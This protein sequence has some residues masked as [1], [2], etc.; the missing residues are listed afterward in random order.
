V[1]PAADIS[2]AGEQDVA[3]GGRGQECADGNGFF[4]SGG[5]GFPC[6]VG[7]RRPHIGGLI[8]EEEIGEPDAVRVERV[9][10]ETRRGL[11]D[12]GVE[13]RRLGL[14]GDAVH[15]G[16]GRSAVV[17]AVVIKRSVARGEHAA[18]H[19]DLKA[20]LRIDRDTRI[21]RGS[22]RSDGGPDAA[23]PLEYA[24]AV[25]SGP[26]VAGRHI[27]R[28]VGMRGSFDYTG[29]AACHQGERGAAIG[30]AMH[31][32]GAADVDVFGDPAEQ[33]AADV[34]LHEA[35]VEVVDLCPRSTGVGGL[36]RAVRRGDRRVG[37][38]RDIH[39][40]AVQRIDRDALAGALFVVGFDVDQDGAGRP[41]VTPVG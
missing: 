14:V 35:A 36:E 2:H 40:I 6:D 3:A 24:A 34:E 10:A 19:D 26:R 1:I 13:P 7:R 25:G 32:V 17:G 11:S 20:V 28:A 38:G 23:V 21:G 12:A 29:R 5:T 30:A 27:H 22:G 31:A 15:K 37:A 4:M 16:P 41:G 9:P 39:D 18:V 8:G 33:A